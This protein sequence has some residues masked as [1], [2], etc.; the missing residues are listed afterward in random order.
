MNMIRTAESGIKDF[1]RDHKTMMGWKILIVISILW[2]LAGT[3]TVGYGDSAHVLKGEHPSPVYSFLLLLGK[4]AN[5]PTACPEC[6]LEAET[7]T[8]PFFRI[9]SGYLRYR[10]LRPTTTDQQE[11]LGQLAGPSAA[12]QRISSRQGC[13]AGGG[14]VHDL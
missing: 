7:L 13:V 10:I 1:A 6:H 9:A 8:A 3:A 5:L 14:S 4:A 2:L 11:R 12:T